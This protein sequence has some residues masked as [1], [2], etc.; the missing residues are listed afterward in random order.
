MIKFKGIGI[1]L[2]LGVLMGILFATMIMVEGYVILASREMANGLVYEI[3][4][5]DLSIF[6]IIAVLVFMVT[7]ILFNTRKIKSMNLNKIGIYL[8]LSVIGALIAAIEFIALGMTCVVKF[9]PDVTS[10]VTE[11]YLLA[12]N[13]IYIVV[14][15]GIAVFL[16]VFTLFVNKK[17]KYI[18]FLSSEVKVIKDEDF[19]KTIEVRGQDE[20]AE[21]CS[22]I[23]NMS[24]ELREKIDNEKKIEQ[25]KNELITNV[26]HDLRTPL[27]SILG[28]VDL[29]KQNGFEDK[30]KF[31]EYI[32][33]IDERSKSLNTLIN[34]LFEYTKLN[35]HD[36]KLNYN[37]VEIGSLVEQLS[38]EYSLIFKKEGLE[39]ISEI[40]E[41]D[42]FVDIDI[43]M[44]VRALENLLI[45]AKKYSVRNS[46]V[47]VKL[48]QE[49]NDIVISVENKVENISQDDLD[50]LFERFYKVDKARKTGDSTGLGLSIV[51]RV[52][53]LHKGLVKAE[54][55]NGVI[56]FKIIL[57][58]QN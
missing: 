1:N 45:N 24:L 58:V 57:L 18:K 14:L 3:A 6:K 47:L 15:L 8:I 32:S 12:M 37:T 53:E 46:Q 7:I 35:S 11:N 33:I 48:L 51:K 10:Y 22:S 54:L 41:E 4:A 27:T 43:Q 30:E 28:Y 9:M 56:K 44:I 49:S 55:I 21:L 25:N 50:N 38:G 34:E 19:G 31:V 40:P 36:I 42:I 52:V 13:M 2:I 20:L 23:N 5:K 26:S 39:L 16:L 29:L 17:V